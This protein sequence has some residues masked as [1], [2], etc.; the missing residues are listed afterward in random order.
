MS[1]YSKVLVE[2]DA[3]TSVR[4]SID[5]GKQILQK[6]LEAYRSKAANFEKL[7]NMSTSSFIEKFNRGKLGDN[8]VWLQWE[9]YAIAIKLLEKKIT[10]TNGTVDRG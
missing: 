1:G 2:K 10:D 9:H 8:K 3:L 4:E 6:K 5:I 7:N